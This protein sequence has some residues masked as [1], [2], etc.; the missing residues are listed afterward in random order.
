MGVHV[1]PV[2]RTAG[3]FT[4]NM[5][6]QEVIVAL[7]YVHVP[8]LGSF[9]YLSTFLALDVRVVGEFL[10][11]VLPPDLWMVRQFASS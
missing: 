4:T 3:T 5:V 2:E 7:G 9:M 10:C 11:V 6:H 1:R 8:H